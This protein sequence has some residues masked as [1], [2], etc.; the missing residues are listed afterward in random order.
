MKF[1]S[2][3]EFVKE[4]LKQAEKTTQINVVFSVNDAKEDKFGKIGAIPLLIFV[5]K[6]ANKEIWDYKTIKEKYGEEIKLTLP[7]PTRIKNGYANIIIY[8]EAT[9]SEKFQ[10]YYYKRCYGDLTN[11]VITKAIESQRQAQ[12]QIEVLDI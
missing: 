5:T 11:K 3:S 4:T 1:L 8:T 9:Y 12:E 10:T 7:K 2:I 6:D